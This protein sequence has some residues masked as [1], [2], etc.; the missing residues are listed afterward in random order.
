MSAPK[1]TIEEHDN[2]SDAITTYH[3]DL[4]SQECNPIGEYSASCNVCRDLVRK[5]FKNR[6]NPVLRRGTTLPQI[7]EAAQ[8]GCSNCAVLHLAIVALASSSQYK[9]LRERPLLFFEPETTAGHASNLRDGDNGPSLFSD[10][11]WCD[12]TLMLREDDTC[13]FEVRVRGCLIKGDIYTTSY[14]SIWPIVRASQH[15]QPLPSHSTVAASIELWIKNCT[16]HVHCRSYIDDSKLPTRV[17]DISPDKKICLVET[18][19]AN[20]K[21]VTLSHCW[22]PRANMIRTLTANYQSHQESIEWTWLP[23]TFRDAITIARSLGIR[24][25][26]IDSLCII[27]DNAMDWEVESSKMA[28]VYAGSYL[29]IAATSSISSAGGLFGERYQWEAS[30]DNVSYGSDKDDIPLRPAGSG[31]VAIRIKHKQQYSDVFVRNVLERSRGEISGWHGA[32]VSSQSTLVSPLLTRAWVFQE[33]LLAPRTVHFHAEEMVFECN[34]GLSCECSMHETGGSE[35]SGVKAE[36][37]KMLGTISSKTK[38]K[39]LGEAM[40][41]WMALVSSYSNLHLSF[42]NDRLPALSGLARLVHDKYGYTYLAGLWSNDLHRQLLWTIRSWR[43]N[44]RAPAGTAPTWSWASLQPPDDSSHKLDCL[45]YF[46]S[47]DLTPI[48]SLKVGIHAE[49]TPSGSNPFGTVQE[50]KLYLTGLVWDYS[51]EIK[52]KVKWDK[53]EEIAYFINGREFSPDIKEVVLGE[54]PVKCVHFGTSFDKEYYLAVET[55]NQVLETEPVYKRVGVLD[56]EQKQ[57]PRGVSTAGGNWTK[58]TII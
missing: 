51:Y 7:I 2:S 55:V 27:Q 41:K 37:S 21:Y 57:G 24:Y 34:S 11:R 26:W 1:I 52:M 44:V 19:N 54:R 6:Y 8:T 42:E 28:Q 3:L 22:G 33:R 56:I 53:S 9:D 15:I 12:V 48:K 47:Q 31:T 5:F 17:L 58:L 29:N 4:D 35:L 10:D 45:V 49:C 30:I 39:K 50:G 43:T 38:K 23:L 32:Q 46:D 25:I 40:D 16:S 13:C 36:F 14:P 18:S 20:G